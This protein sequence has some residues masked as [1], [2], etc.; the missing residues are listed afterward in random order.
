MFLR[1]RPEPPGL[2]SFEGW[3]RTLPSRLRTGVLF[4][5]KAGIIG[6]MVFKILARMNT[7]SVSYSRSSILRV[8]SGLRL[9]YRQ[10]GG[11]LIIE[12]VP[13]A[14]RPELER[15]LQQ[16]DRGVAYRIEV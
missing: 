2:P 13:Q 5:F 12:D 14:V 9:S 7:R 1:I 11:V 3:G 4:D 15:Q 16:V 6:A 8:L 10:E